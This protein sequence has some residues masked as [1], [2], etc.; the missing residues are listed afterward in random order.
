MIITGFTGPYTRSTAKFWQRPITLFHICAG[1]GSVPNFAIIKSALEVHPEI[2]HTLI[3]PIASG[4]ILFLKWSST[5]WNA[6]IRPPDRDS[7]ADARRQ[8]EQTWLQC[9]LGASQS[10][11]AEGTRPRGSELSLLCVR[12]GGLRV[13]AE[14]PPDR[15]GQSP[16]HASWNPCWRI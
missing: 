4:R 10:G 12:A 6:S 7:H 8:S 3:Y 14:P 2:H 9:P 15:K 11:S 1:S 5:L 13:R 16:S